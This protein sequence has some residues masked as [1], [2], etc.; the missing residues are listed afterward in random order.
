MKRNPPKQASSP[1]APG[2]Y[3]QEVARCVKCGA[4]RAVCPAFLHAR[5]ES[6]SPRG[7][8]ALVQAVLDGRLPVSKI[9]EDRLA[10]CAAC[11]ACESVCPN[12]V[13]VTTIIQ[14]AK[15][16]ATAESGMGV[17]KRALSGVVMHPALFRAAAWLAP[18]AL[19]YSRISDCGLRI[20]DFGVRN[21]KPKTRDSKGTVAF[22]PGCAI[23]HF[24]PEIKSA[25]INV[26]HALGFD[27]VIPEGLQCCG[28]PLLSLGDRK[29]AEE[30]AARNASVFAGLDVD[31]I[32]TA[33]ASC[34]L[35]FK[36]EY[37]K[38]LRPGVKHPFVLDIHEF[39]SVPLAGA[40][41]D[42][43]QKTITWHDPCHLGRGQGLS[44]TARDILRRIPGLT[45][46]EMRNADRCCGFGGVM[47]ITHRELSDGI[48]EDK[49]TSIIASGASLV[50]TGCPG[51]RM[52][53]TDAL[54]R[55]GSDIGV[56]HTVQVLE[57]S[58]Q[59]ADCAM[60]IAELEMTGPC[61]KGPGSRI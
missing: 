37:P 4:C 19:H 44:K 5:E 41:L 25:A 6:L 9:Y 16:Q 17:I 18:V 56:V 59:S 53:I 39:L 20:A 48:A 54:R 13:P 30:L 40:A 23:E 26:L 28:R 3:R 21:E 11:L 49:I 38:L 31:A 27:V 55:A 14:R 32:V 61:V 60:R 51:C 34:G 10:T 43:V 7:R 33:C 12:S 52:Q 58:L 1:Q 42:P 47:R 45:L 22:F 35:T 2:S 15:E 29:A 50:A 46:A 57:A 24:Q 8:M 36:R